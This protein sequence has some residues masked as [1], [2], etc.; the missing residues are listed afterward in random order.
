[1][2]DPE[3]TSAGVWVHGRQYT[4]RVVTVTND[5]IFEEPVFNSTRDFP[6]L[7]EEIR[8][9][10]TYATDRA[11][12]EK[13]LLDVAE[14]HTADIQRHAEPFRGRLVARYH[15]EIDPLAPHVFFRI[16]DNWLELSLRL[17]SHEKRTRELKDQISRDILTEFDAAKIGIASTTIDIVGFPPLRRHP[18]STNA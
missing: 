18:T 6:F 10:I 15:M 9:P 8:I 11:R 14:K 16:T 4:G 13:I 2:G 3:L 7:W 1:M 5:K 17:I 12:A